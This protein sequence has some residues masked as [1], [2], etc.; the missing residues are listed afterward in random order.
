M[1]VAGRKIGG[2]MRTFVVNRVFNLV[3]QRDKQIGLTLLLDLETSS[4]ENFPDHHN[5]IL[6]DVSLELQGVC[7]QVDV[8]DD[9]AKLEE[10][11]Q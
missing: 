6:K 5:S 2:D 9:W 3:T 7:S 10:V 11:K 8:S 4:Q 1:I